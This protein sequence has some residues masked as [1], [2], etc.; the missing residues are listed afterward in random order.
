[1]IP[2][3]P[4]DYYATDWSGVC[5]IVNQA[6]PIGGKLLHFGKYIGRPIRRG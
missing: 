6:G 3:T 5:H 2:F 4:K 1:M